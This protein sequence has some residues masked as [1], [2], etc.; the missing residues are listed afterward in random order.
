[1]PGPP[2]PL[3]PVPGSPTR[4]GKTEAR[5]LTMLNR[6]NSDNHLGLGGM[7]APRGYEQ[8]LGPRESFPSSS[9]EGG[10]QS[11]GP[12]QLFGSSGRVL[13]RTVGAGSGNEEGVVPRV[14][15]QAHREMSRSVIA[16][17]D[18]LVTVVDVYL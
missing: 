17:G 11:S 16:R 14:N 3:P 18:R 15:A 1:M 5:P 4:Q 8:G 9:Y 13:P 2:P 7:L 12:S 6:G 10:Q